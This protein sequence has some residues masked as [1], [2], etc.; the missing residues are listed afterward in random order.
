MIRIRIVVPDV[1]ENGVDE[2]KYQAL[3]SEI[4]VQGLSELVMQGSEV[5]VH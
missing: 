3:G 5:F 1:K 4:A 2:Q